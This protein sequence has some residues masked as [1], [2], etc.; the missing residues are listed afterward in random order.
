MIGG[1]G[2]LNPAIAVFVGIKDHNSTAFTAAMVLAE[3]LAALLVISIYFAMS[4]S[5]SSPSSPSSSS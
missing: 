5:P 2:Y 4:P 3:L 1:P